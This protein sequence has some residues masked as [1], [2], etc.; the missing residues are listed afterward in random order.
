[1]PDDVYR[2]A[3]IKAAERGTSV[4]ALV[5]GYLRGLS[6]D[7][8]AEFARLREV[9]LPYRD[10]AILEAARAAGCAQVLSED[11]GA[12]RDY[13]GVRVVNPFA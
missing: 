12:G 11:L 8:D 4:S 7:E 13:D 9:Q 2:E 3:R 1:M 6:G 5:A 10:A